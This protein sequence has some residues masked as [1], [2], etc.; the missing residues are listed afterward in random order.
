MPGTGTWSRSRSDSGG[1]FVAENDDE[2]GD[3]LGT[4]IEEHVDR[5]PQRL[6]VVSRKGRGGVTDHGVILRS[7]ALWAAGPR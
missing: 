2:S 7:G 4:P 5:R 1:L 3:A 6:P